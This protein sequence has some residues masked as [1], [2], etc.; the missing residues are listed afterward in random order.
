MILISLDEYGRF[1]KMDH[2]P[3]FIGGVLFDDA[4]DEQEE[5]IERKRIEAYYRKAISDAGAEFHYPEDLHSN[6]DK[7]RDTN[8]I[9][10]VKLKVSET[11]SEFFQKGTYGGVPLQDGRGKKIRDRKGK[12]H[13]FVMLKSDDGKRS[14]LRENASMLAKDDYAANLYV[15]MAGS[16]V[17]RIIFHNPLYSGQMPPVKIDIATRSSED[18]HT[19]DREK[20]KQFQNQA[21]KINK[22]Q[23]SA[24]KYFSIMNS[25]I[26]RTL[27][28]QEMINSG[29][30]GVKIKEIY[31]KSIQYG[32]KT[33]EME[34]LYLSDSICSVL[35]YL[36]EGE[37]ADGWLE[38]II[39]KVDNLNS[40]S[41][42][43]VF[44]YDEIDNDFSAAWSQYEQE[45]LFE[46]L[47]ISYDAKNK[48]GKFAEHYKNRW[49]PY[50]EKRINL[51]VSSKCFTKCVNAL[52]DMVMIN[53][54]NQDK[55]LYIMQQFE[56]MVQ[57]VSGK[58]NNSDDRAKVLYTLYDA[59]LSAF[60]HIGDAGKAVEY[61]E[62][63]KPY[64]SY[65]GVDIFLRASN[66][67]AVCL[68][69]SFE[70]DKARKLAQ[71]T[72]INQKLVSDMKR[73]ILHIEDETKFLD[74]AK[75]ISQLARIMAE[76][77]EPEAEK[78]FKSALEKLE[79][80]SANYKITQ[81][82]LLHFYADMGDEEKFEENAIDYFDGRTTY[83]QRLKYIC[84]RMDQENPAFSI[85][86]AMYV[87][88]RGLFRFGRKEIDDNLWQKLINLPETMEGRVGG[89]LEGHPWEITYKYLE[90]LAI[91]RKDKIA[92]EKFSALRN[93][94]LKFK[95]STIT[96]VEKFGDAEIA[97]F[98]G[99]KQRRDD[100]TKELVIFL[101]DYF[102][103]MKDVSFSQDGDKRYQ[104]LERYFTFMY[105]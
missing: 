19:M 97:D 49:F 35:G 11:L 90:M 47:S 56:A 21:Y 3:L 102:D 42:N 105:R 38:Q 44:G 43:L 50:L 81:S 87:L 5:S 70:W 40:D 64:A 67:L 10:P 30:T 37:S 82:Y 25:D 99:E 41:E 53:N 51:S 73:E 72:V 1:E 80:G 9:R 103:I 92:Q 76:K 83:N 57:N 18:I 104:E 100:A 23:N 98:A 93:S 74:E 6:G 22:I 85:K 46:A 88:V 20:A 71:D 77:H 79:I 34:F 55:L 29:N 69:D 95:G 48:K 8:V 39:E 27:I 86:Y 36:L 17:N 96:A 24:Y 78:E 45:N 68:E 84:R 15:H 66:K 91:D 14:L 63:C 94:C 31:V 26:Y 62:K 89:I 58:Y 65:I 13:I 54:L 75:T 52:S 12:Y 32:S 2:K 33:K 101:K 7:V 61:Y 16:I 4:G 60:C 59:G 28:A